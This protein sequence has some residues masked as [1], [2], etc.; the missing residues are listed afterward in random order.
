[1]KFFQPIKSMVVFVREILWGRSHPEFSARC[2]RTKDKL[3]IELSQNGTCLRMLAR[4]A[5]HFHVI[6]ILYEG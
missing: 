3:E 6:N 1:M 4:E 2:D 5:G